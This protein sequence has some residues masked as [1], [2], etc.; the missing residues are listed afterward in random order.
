MIKTCDMES[1][2][3]NEWNCESVIIKEHDLSSCKPKREYKYEP[4]I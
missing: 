2:I 3:T 1:P 4:R